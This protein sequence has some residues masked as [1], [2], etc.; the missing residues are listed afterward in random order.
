MCSVFWEAWCTRFTYVAPFTAFCVTL[1]VW[2]LRVFVHVCV[3]IC[4]Q[5]P[6]AKYLK[7]HFQEVDAFQLTIQ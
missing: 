5:D 2:S 6:W 1:R 7:Q 3:Y 4:V